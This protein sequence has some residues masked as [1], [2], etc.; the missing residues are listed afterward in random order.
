MLFDFLI[1]PIRCVGNESG[2]LIGLECLKMELGEPDDSG[3]RRPIPIDGP[4]FAGDAVFPAGPLA[5]Y[6]IVEIPVSG[7]LLISIPISR[8]TN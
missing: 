3:R 2:W 1:L 4:A 5:A 6:G 8:S 7:I